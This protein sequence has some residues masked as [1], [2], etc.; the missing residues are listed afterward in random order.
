[1][2]RG[3]HLRELTLS[4]PPSHAERVLHTHPPPRQLRHRLR[5][6]P[7]PRQAPLPHSARSLSLPFPYLLRL[8]LYRQLPLQQRRR[9]RRL[10][11]LPPLL[12]RLLLPLLLLRLL[13]LLLL[14]L[15]KL[16]Q[17]LLLLLLLQRPRRRL[18]LPLFSLLLLQLCF[19][20]L[21]QV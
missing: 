11:R 4:T 15:R 2:R 5:P 13:R 3:V 19:S 12:P 6:P 14:L 18:R 9:R 10:L 20:L 1:M 7:L 16:L 17:R 21:L 8:P